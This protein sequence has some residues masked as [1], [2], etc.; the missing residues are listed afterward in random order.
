M[1]PCQVVRAQKVTLPSQMGP[2]TGQPPIITDM[3]EAARVKGVPCRKR[4]GA[5]KFINVSL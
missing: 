2:G 1:K 4:S 3:G 5:A